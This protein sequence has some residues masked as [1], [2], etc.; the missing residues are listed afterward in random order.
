M[1]QMESAARA[2][3]SYGSSF[4]HG[5]KWMTDYARNGT[6]FGLFADAL[7]VSLNMTECA[8]CL[9][10]AASRKPGRRSLRPFLRSGE[11]R[12]HDRVLVDRTLRN[13]ALEARITAWLNSLWLSWH[14]WIVRGKG[15]FGWVGCPDL[16]QLIK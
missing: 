6:V 15:H 12:T 3:Y 4:I 2:F 14:L 13:L 1:N 8:V 5:C 9:F 11:V 10:E 7:A 16:K